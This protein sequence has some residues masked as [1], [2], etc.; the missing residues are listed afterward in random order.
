MFAVVSCRVYRI[1]KDTHVHAFDIPSWTGSDVVLETPTSA[2]CPK[3]DKVST[4][5]SP[6]HAVFVGGHV[7]TV[8]ALFRSTSV[9]LFDHFSS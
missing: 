9:I 8:C 1:F 7:W 4:L 6:P 5:R 3:G 2:M